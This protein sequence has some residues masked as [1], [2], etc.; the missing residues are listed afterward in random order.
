MSG[1]SHADLVARTV[2]NGLAGPR[3]ATVLAA[4]ERV[5]GVQSQD[6]RP[7][8]LAVR[9][10]S[11]GLRRSDVDR[12][13]ADGTVV[14]TWAMRGTLHMVAAGDAGWLVSLLG[15][16]FA[17]ANR[18]RRHSLGLDDALAEVGAQVIAT[19]QPHSRAELVALLA[20]NGIR[21]D[22]KTQAPAHL[23]A[24]AA[25]TGRIRRG[26]D[27][28]DTEPTYVRFDPGP[29]VDEQRAV[30]RLADRYRSGYGPATAE[31]FAA[32]SGLPLGK[33]RAGF[34]EPGDPGEPELVADP[35]PTTR[36]LGHFDTYLLGY[37]SRDGIVP[38]EFAKRVQA[39]GGFIMPVVLRDGVVVGTWRMDKNK[40][41]SEVDVEEEAQDIARW[42]SD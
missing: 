17:H 24:Y 18:G 36:L 32:W 22:P 11:T 34:G 19:E 5:V 38:P 10:R 12:A 39:G 20:D 29:P 33:A 23:I 7:A 14:R 42:N 28:S 30:E 3:A 25:M 8:R 31:D 4:V 26:P 40:V 35:G 16:R 9:A 2:A 37:K 27:R 15:P 1:P 13:V 21:L 41:V 6:V